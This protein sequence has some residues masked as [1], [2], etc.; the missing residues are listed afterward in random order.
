MTDLSTTWCGLKLK[1]PLVLAA[2]PL[3]KRIDSLVRAEQAGA[4]AVVLPSL[5]EEQL[6][7]QSFALDHHLS[8]GEG[9]NPEADSYLPEVLAAATGPDEYLNQIQV[10][11]GALKVPVVASLNGATPGGWTEY[12]KRIADAGADA[13]ELNL[14]WIPTDP[15]ETG[16]DLERRYCQLVARIRAAVKLPLMVKIHPFFTS[17]PNT[18]R[19]LH[20]AGADGLVLFN[21]FYQPDMDIDQMEVVPNLVLSTSHDLRLPLR[22][23]AILAGKVEADLAL[24][25]GVHTGAD[26]VKAILAGAS[27]ACIA[28][29][30]LAHGVQR[31]AR[32]LDELKTWMADK[33]YASVGE[34]RGAMSAAS[35]GDPAIY[36]RANYMKA[37]QSLDRHWL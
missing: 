6:R 26:L 24:T 30:P 28:S 32:I 13:L 5:F 10:A 15:A 36:E 3:S 34:M 4:G 19:R 9:G 27:V 14:Y 33:E 7:H 31:I 16:E 8:R 22:W 21:R 23:T 29:A 17:L 1:T 37:L 2:S 11:K 35:V 25:S 20:E 18:A 12:A